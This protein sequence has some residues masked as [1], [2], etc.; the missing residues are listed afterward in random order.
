M[1]ATLVSGGLCGLLFFW[2]SIR[3]VQTRTSAKVAIGDGGDAI[4][5]SRIRAHAN[6]AEYV[7]MLLLLMLAIE[8]S[9]K[10]TPLT[11]WV[12]ALAL[13]VLRLLHA[14]GLSRPVTNAYRA[15]G[16]L[17]TWAMLAGLSIWAL[18]L[19]LAFVR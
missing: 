19:A 15:I 8:L 4:L 17:C 3:V 18:V 5:L 10:A 12:P 7:P 16:A 2:L 13:P 11:L 14:I 6:F 9:L 1:V